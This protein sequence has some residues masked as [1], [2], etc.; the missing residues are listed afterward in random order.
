M[1][2]SPIKFQEALL[3]MFFSSLISISAS[4]QNLTPPV[5]KKIPHVENHFSDVRADDYYWLKDKSNPEVIKY[6]EEENAYTQAL[7]K[8]TEELQDGLYKEL[9]GRIKETDLTVPHRI[10]DYFYYSRTEQGKNYPIYCRKKGS[11]EAPEELILDVNTLAEGHKFFSV[12]AVAVSP[13]HN[14]M[15][16]ST[17][18]TGS[19][20]YTLFVKDLTSGQL[21]S[22]QIPNT[23]YGVEWGND[24]QTFFYITQDD[25][26]RPYKLFKHRLGADYQNDQ[27]IHHET[28]QAFY[29]NLSKT[30]SR[31]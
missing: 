13:N 22:E 4:G 21:L 3:L 14:L 27:L 6:L 5:A 26:K 28:D 19:E 16:F 10:D 23:Y 9:L 11:L 17:D 1:R 2:I 25:A 7:M 15:A 29:V 12:G 24:N 8:P 20:T 30:R 18:T 31:K